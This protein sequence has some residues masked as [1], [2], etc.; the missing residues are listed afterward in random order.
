[1]GEAFAFLVGFLLGGLLGVM[2][3]VIVVGAKQSRGD[4]EL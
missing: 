4:D 1:M 3:M 2:I